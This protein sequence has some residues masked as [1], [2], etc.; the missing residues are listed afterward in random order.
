M[1]LSSIPLTSCANRAQFLLNSGQLL[2]PGCQLLLGPFHA[3][4]VVQDAIPALRRTAGHV[5]AGTDDVTVQRDALGVY[6]P[7]KGDSLSRVQ[8]A[9]DYKKT[10]SYRQC[11][12]FMFVFN[13]SASSITF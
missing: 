8:V 3:E 13:G 6:V 10:I 11:F 5:T 7:V 12:G 2:L 4:H 9:T 1:S